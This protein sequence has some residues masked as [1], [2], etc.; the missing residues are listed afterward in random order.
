MPLHTRTVRCPTCGYM[1][2]EVLLD[3]HRKACTARTKK[4]ASLK[5]KKAK[6]NGSKKAS[7][8]QAEAAAKRRR[9]KAQQRRAREGDLYAAGLIVDKRHTD[10]SHH[11]T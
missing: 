1:I 8:Q 7:S 2:N 3:G 5:A 10:R 11:R 9:K 4:Q 6:K